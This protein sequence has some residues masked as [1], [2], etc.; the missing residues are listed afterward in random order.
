MKQDRT[1]ST[2]MNVWGF[3]VLLICVV[4]T[5]KVRRRFSDPG[6]VLRLDLVAQSLLLQDLLYIVHV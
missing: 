4:S 1:R 5:T 6:V 3:G 2:T